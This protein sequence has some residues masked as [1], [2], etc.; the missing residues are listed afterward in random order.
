MM[1]SLIWSPEKIK[2]CPLDTK[3]AIRIGNTFYWNLE[4]LEDRKLKY[5]GLVNINANF[6][7][8]TNA[9]V[10]SNIIDKSIFNPNGQL[11]VIADFYTIGK[12]DIS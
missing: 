12:H 4:H 10:L 7:W 5:I 3:N 1:Q 9:H 6:K 11:L 2:Y 8:T